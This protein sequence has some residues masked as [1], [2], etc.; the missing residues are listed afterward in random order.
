MGDGFDSISALWAN[1]HGSVIILFF[2]LVPMLFENRLWKKYLLIIGVC[3]L[4]TLINPRGILLWSD[5]F[6]CSIQVAMNSAENGLPHEFSLAD[7]YLF[8][9]GYWQ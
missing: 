5:T 9:L 6:H 8:L 2:L 1:L 7:V 4:A 3:F